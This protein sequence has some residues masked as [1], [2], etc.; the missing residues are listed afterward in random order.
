MLSGVLCLTKKGEQV[1]H[2]LFQVTNSRERLL[3]SAAKLA[4]S[5]PEL[6]RD[7]SNVLSSI[8]AETVFDKSSTSLAGAIL[9]QAEF[10]PKLIK[11]LQESPELV[12]AAF[13]KLRKC[14]MYRFS[15]DVEW[16]HQIP[17]FLVTDPSGIRI[18]VTGN[19]LGL[20]KPRSTWSE[21]L[22]HLT[23]SIRLS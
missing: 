22:S 7:G 2:D 16:S 17:I 5:L 11:D 13:E 18:S 3:V 14:R 19:V 21:K 10:V 8:W 15:W 23:V 20:K 12:I 9:S 4:Q 1:F 6:K